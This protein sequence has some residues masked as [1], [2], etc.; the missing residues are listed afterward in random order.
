MV[1]EAWCYYTRT[2][3]KHNFHDTFRIL[4]FP[5]WIHHQP[6]VLLVVNHTEI[7]PL[8]VTE[9]LKTSAT[10]NS[11]FKD[12]HGKTIRTPRLKFYRFPVDKERRRKWVS[13]I[14]RDKWQPNEYS[15]LCSTH[16]VAGKALVRL[17]LQAY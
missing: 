15:R 16:F 8:V 10:D 1:K 4:V 2:H 3:Y 6:L 17:T 9:S 11:S 14:R 12:K 5:W 7:L 13:A